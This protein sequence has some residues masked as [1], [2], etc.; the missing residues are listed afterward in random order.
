MYRHTFLGLNIK[1]RH[2]FIKA[3]AGARIK[4]MKPNDPFAYLIYFQHDCVIRYKIDR[5]HNISQHEVYNLK[6]GLQKFEQ[7]GQAVSA[8]K[9]RN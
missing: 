1:Q 6:D 5:K 2:A 4:Q 9:N 7:T 8:I 3:E